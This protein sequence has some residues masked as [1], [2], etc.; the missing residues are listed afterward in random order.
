MKNI[1]ITL[2]AMFIANFRAVGQEFELGTLYKAD[3][4][5]YQIGLLSPSDTGWNL[6]I[7]SDHKGESWAFNR[8]LERLTVQRSEK[9][10]RKSDFLFHFQIGDT[11][12]YIYEHQTGINKREIWLKQDHSDEPVK[13]LQFSKIRGEFPKLRFELLRKGILAWYSPI[14]LSE[15]AN[16][17]VQFVE[18]SASGIQNFNWDI[19][20]NK[21]DKLIRMLR[22]DVHKNTILL[23]TK[24]FEISPVEKRAFKAN[25]G[26]VLYSFP[27]ASNEVNTYLLHPEGV[28][29][30]LPLINI[31]KNQLTAYCF[32]G[33]KNDRKQRYLC[34]TKI[35]TNTTERTSKMYD[36]QTLGLPR[37][38]LTYR[39][40]SQSFYGLRVLDVSNTDSSWTLTAE[41]RDYR[42]I[43]N[44][45]SGPVI[46][47]VFGPVALIRKDP[48]GLNLSVIEKY[49]QSAN[50]HAT[51]LSYYECKTDSSRVFV[52]TKG[53]R[54][55]LGRPWL[56]SISKRAN[57][58]ITEVSNDDLS[59]EVIEL[60][61][62]EQKIAPHWRD[63]F[64][65]DQEIVV[66]VSGKKYIGL[67][68]LRP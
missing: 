27:Y 17:K 38:Q 47:Y 29:P 24:E 32:A 62:L 59:I 11:N 8:D 34:E 67:G 9:V 48:S 31:E 25:Y 53:H 16:S 14:Q 2:H 46:S 6:N 26:Y 52:H 68:K 18:F 21:P 64:R 7:F 54:Y 28:F 5:F 43:G 30:L 49:Q 10:K 41:F 35:N 39:W 63:A 20:L 56:R 1:L 12:G 23:T 19:T 51:H 45:A 58:Q 44:S 33:K 42:I 3:S 50:D 57:I 65:I 61:R 15:E 66:P 60:P 55:F 40:L 36:L 13:L 37:N 22:L 4:K